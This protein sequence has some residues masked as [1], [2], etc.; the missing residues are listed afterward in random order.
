MNFWLKPRKWK[1]WTRAVHFRGLEDDLDLRF[2]QFLPIYKCFLSTYKLAIMKCVNAPSP[3][4]WMW[5]C[6]LVIDFVT[7]ERSGGSLL[8][9]PQVSVNGGNALSSIAPSG[10]TALRHPLSDPPPSTAFHFPSASIS[11]AGRHLALA[12]CN[13]DWKAVFA[14]K[15]WRIWDWVA[16]VAAC[17]NTQ[18]MLSETITTFKHVLE[19]FLC[20]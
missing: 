17:R 9:N 8:A 11:Q 15:M 4:W 14:T 20:H 3:E 16:S 1:P 13:P 5:T 2:N 19:T 18:R 12:A 6:C 7:N 10:R